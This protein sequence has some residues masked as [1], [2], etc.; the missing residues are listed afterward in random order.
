MDDSYSLARELE[1]F[2]KAE[3][4][5]ARRVSKVASRCAKLVGADERICAAAGFYYRI[6]VI[7]GDEIAQSGVGI[8]QR[9][10]FPEEVARIICEYN[11]EIEPLST[12]ESAIVHM[13]DALIKK[14]EALQNRESMSS[15]WNQDMVIYQTLNE[16]SSSGIYDNSGLSMNRFLQIRE[17]LVKADKLL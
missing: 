16:F 4:I 13:V 15:D 3:F 1:V 11:G 7:E 12:S 2:S 10:S 14:L 9:E 17:Y 8:V 6:G 5:H